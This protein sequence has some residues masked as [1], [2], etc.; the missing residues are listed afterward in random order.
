MPRGKCQT[1]MQKRPEPGVCQRSN[2]AMFKRARH[3]IRQG[4]KACRKVPRTNCEAVPTQKC[5]SVPKQQCQT[6]SDQE[7]QIVPRQSCQAVPSQS[8]QTV[9]QQQ[10]RTVPREVCQR[11]TV[12][13]SAI[14]SQILATL[15]PRIDAV[16]S[17]ALSSQSNRQVTQ[18]SSN[19]DALIRQQQLLAAKR[20]QERR[21]LA[22]IQ[23]QQSLSQSVGTSQS[24]S[25]GSNLA[26]IFGTGH[27][28]THSVDGQLKE[29]YNL[30]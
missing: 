18:V 23:Q 14:I 11:S 20:E 5:Q 26:S 29:Q 7:C 8:C 30:S 9:P 10:C 6:V 1:R 21:R 3:K 12:S 19:R 24:S 25:S 22:L 17:E 2:S 13:Q 4:A 27:E 16:V 15:Q 28:V